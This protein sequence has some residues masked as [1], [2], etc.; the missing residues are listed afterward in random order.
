MLLI[1]T[2]QLLNLQIVL[3]VSL[4]FL[5]IMIMFKFS[6]FLDLFLSLIIQRLDFGISVLI[7]LL[8]VI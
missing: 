5:S 3:G 7:L 4:Q 2:M 8:Q 6:K 1:L